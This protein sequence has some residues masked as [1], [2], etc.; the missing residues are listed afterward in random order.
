METQQ[1][2]HTEMVLSGSG[3]V[4]KAKPEL[5]DN[6][7]FMMIVWIIFVVFF[8]SSHSNSGS[9]TQELNKYPKNNEEK[10]LYDQ[11]KTLE[12]T[13]KSVWLKKREVENELRKIEMDGLMD[14]KSNPYDSELKMDKLKMKI[15]ELEMTEEKKYNELDN[16]RYKL[17]NLPTN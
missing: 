7:G 17:Q 11:V 1:L 14:D 5:T 3:T 6:F 2:T 13:L 4:S 16:V 12:H 15:E 8:V 10:K 9:H